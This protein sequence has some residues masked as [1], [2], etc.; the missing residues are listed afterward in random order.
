M[1]ALRDFLARLDDAGALINTVLLLDGPDLCHLSAVDTHR[2][3]LEVADAAWCQLCE[4]TWRSKSARFHLTPERARLL[5]MSSKNVTWREHY[6]QAFAEGRRQSLRPEELNTLRWAFNFTPSAGGRGTAS[7]QFAEFQARAAGA[8]DGHLILRGYP[9]LP[10]E[11]SACGKV[12]DI[13]NFPPHYVRRLDTWEWE[14]TN[15]NVTFVSCFNDD[16]QY[17]E[18]GFLEVTVDDVVEEAHGLIARVDVE[19]LLHR[20]GGLPRNAVLLHLLHSVLQ[21]A[22]DEA[23]AEIE[24]EVPRDEE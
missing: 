21:G 7:M 14:I 11:L 18:R 4:T 1:S 10:Y 9:P 15:S 8:A 22:E 12:L 5:A 24:T 16:V 23:A 6:M 13:A 3:A 20:G 19:Q 17:S 2:H